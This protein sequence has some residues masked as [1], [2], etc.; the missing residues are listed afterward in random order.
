LISFSGG[1]VFGFAPFRDSAALALSLAALALCSAAMALAV[2]AAVAQPLAVSAAMAQP[3]F[4]IPGFASPF[5]FNHQPGLVACCDRKIC[6]F[7]GELFGEGN[8]W[9]GSIDH[10]RF[11]VVVASSGFDVF[12]SFNSSLLFFLFLLQLF[13][14]LLSSLDIVCC[15]L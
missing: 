12:F 3:F 14:P 13:T 1:P 8:L 5:S 15:F 11:V 4:R 2:S 6:V 7:E 10:C 9:G